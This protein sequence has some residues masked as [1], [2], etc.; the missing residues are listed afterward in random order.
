MAQPIYPLSLSK[1]CTI[2]AQDT[3]TYQG[4]VSADF[5]YASAL[6]LPTGHGGYVASI[7][8]A[9]I[10][11][12]F[13]TTL[14]H[15]DQPDTFTSH[16]RYLNASNAGAITIHIANIKLGKS[17]STMHFSAKQNG[18]EKVVGYALNINA[19]PRA[20]EGFTI[21]TEPLLTPAPLPISFADLALGRD[22]HWIC[23]ENPF[24]PQH[25]RKSMTQ[26]KYVLPRAGQPGSMVSDGWISPV[27]P[28]ERFTN[29]SLGWYVPNSCSLACS[30][31]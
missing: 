8:L 24:H 25:T 14:K 5:C 3:N 11:C 6:A 28:G 30:K 20:R 26:C 13:K 31:Y 12:H 19:S 4:E 23:H 21:S 27:Q 15:L 7:I 16:F 22:A 9:A 10:E 2:R 18:T 1:G 29:L 17:S